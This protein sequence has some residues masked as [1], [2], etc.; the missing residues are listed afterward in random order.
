MITAKPRG[1]F[2][3]LHTADWHLGKPLGEHSREPEHAYFLKFLHETIVA[4]Q[5][6]ALVVA[7]DVFDSANPPQT[8]L[9]QYYDF[10]SRLYRETLCAVV[11]VGGNHDSPGNLEAPRL[12]LKSLRTHVIG[13][14]TERLEDMLVPLPSPE[15][16]QLVVAGVPFL[17]DRDLRLGQSGQSAADIQRELVKGIRA[18]YAG[19]AEAAKKLAQGRPVMATGHL[20]VVGCKNSDSEREIHIG[21][22]G[23]VTAEVFPSEFAYVALGHLHRPQRAGADHARYSG[24]P[25][26]LSFGE[27]ADIKE[28]RL[29]DFDSQGLS[30]QH[31]LPVPVSRQLAQIRAR[32]ERLEAEL[33]SFRPTDSPLPCWVEVVVED[34]APGDNLFE[35]AQKHAQGRGYEV[36][37]VL[38]KRTTE[39]TGTQD[40]G[41]ET[42]TELDQALADPKKIFDLRLERESGL[43]EEEKVVLRLAFT[44][45]CEIQAEKAEEP[46]GVRTGGHA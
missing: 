8:A 25:F 35:L 14:R 10:L 44:E 32:P 39:L 13:S 42:E 17:R 27:A 18:C 36:I 38:T 26:A 7:G 22:L 15:N 1:I 45:L 40:T 30:A 4:H 19:V 37:R 28:L 41:A 5:V 33:K 11:V 9:A 3:A 23:A 43:N 34:P 12:L 46:A 2:R 6:D 24:S 29:L 31:S 21:G 20:T 16:P